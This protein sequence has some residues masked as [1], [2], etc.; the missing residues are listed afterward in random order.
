MAALDRRLGADTAVA[1]V[2][3]PVGDRRR[4]RVVADDDRRRAAARARARRSAVDVVAFAASS[5]PVGSS[6]ISRRG[7]CARARRA[8]PVA[9]RR[10]ELGRMCVRPVGEADAFE[11]LVRAAAVPRRRSQ[12]RRLRARR[13]RA[14]QLGCERARVVL[15]GVAEHAGAV[16]AEP[17]SAQLAQVVAEHAHGARRRR[18]EPG[19]DPQERRSCRSRSARRRRPPRRPDAHRQPLQ[20]DR[21]ASL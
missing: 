13:A 3:D 1:D 17:A 21:A 7:R 19:E 20:G 10:R 16:L 11:E 12:Q 8:R 14:R 18:V 6:A 5:S 9:A 15:V 2:Q 4:L